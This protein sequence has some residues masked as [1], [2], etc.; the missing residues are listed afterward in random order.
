MHFPLNIPI[1]I[2]WN[3]QIIAIPNLRLVL[4]LPLAKGGKKGNKKEN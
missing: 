1:R 3:G 4:N 2:H